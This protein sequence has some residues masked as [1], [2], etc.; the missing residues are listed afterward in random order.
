MRIAF[1]TVFALA[2]ITPAAPDSP[3]A[4]E[5][6]DCGFKMTGIE[7]TCGF[8][9]VRENRAE[10]GG[11]KIPIHFVRAGATG[12]APKPDPIVFLGGGPGLH[13]TPGANTVIWGNRGR[14][15]DRDLIVVD[16]RGTGRSNPLDCFDHGT[17]GGP[18]V[19]RRVF[20]RDFFDGE[21]FRQC[22]GEL[23]KN[24]DLT[25]YTTTASV[26]DLDAVRRA[27]GYERVNLSGGS[28]G[29][30]W[31]LEYMRRHADSVRAAVLYGVAP[32]SEMLVER[33]ARD[34]QR[35]LDALIAACAAEEACSEAYPEFGQQLQRVLAAV[36]KKPVEVVVRSGG[37][38]IPVTMN[39]EQLVTAIRF[40]FY[41]VHHAAALPSQVQAAT[42]GDYTP[43]ADTV[44]ALS[45]QL[46]NAVAEGLW[47]S[48]KCAEEL[49]FIDY[50]KARRQSAGTVLGTYR[51]ESEREICSIWPR[52]KIPPDFNEPVESD[53]PALLIAGEFDPATPVDLAEKTVPH[54]SNG[55]LVR[56]AKRSHWGLSGPCVDRMVDRFLETG[57]VE[58]IDTGCASEFERPAFIIE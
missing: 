22:L 37:E 13:A 11:R 27:L 10:P 40:M 35:D 1:A 52:G 30:R 57:S 43:F 17:E 19:V 7:L 49:P 23:S 2:S 46:H 51:L 56:V 39:H 8:V 50:E 21:T 44:T 34:F 16:Q 25:Q 38:K 18:E 15:E 28:Y 47:A 31:A 12:E 36:K 3:P 32:P 20:T 55:L 42:E 14:L 41:S 24:A 5:T 54:L 6:M 53:V 4:F 29:T 26:E 9:E 45:I 58:G 33:V 48:V